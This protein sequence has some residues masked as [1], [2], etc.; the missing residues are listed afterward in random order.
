[1]PAQ[2]FLIRHGQST[3]NAVFEA[4]GIDPMHYDARLS[5]LG[6]QQVEAARRA[7][8]ELPAPDL[9]IASPL[10]RAIETSLGLFGHAGVPIEITC[11]H[12]EQVGAS[13][14]IGRPPATLAAEFPSLSF[15]H[16]SDPWWHDQDHGPD[17]LPVEPQPLFEQRV[18]SF[19]AW[20]ATL[21][22]PIVMIVGHAGFFRQLTGH[23][24]QNCEIQRWSPL[25]PRPPQSGRA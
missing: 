12:R 9:V 5:P 6:W 1:M 11:R 7:L 3:F 22:A 25:M 20:T 24:F 2:I 14:D 15:A 4:T 18:E 17:G 19:R 10:T 23:R 16:L 8:S 21:E 13:C